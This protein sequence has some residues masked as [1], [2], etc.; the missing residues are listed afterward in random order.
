MATVN[1]YYRSKKK[2]TELTVKLRYS[3]KSENYV[4][5]AKTP[6]STYLYVWEKYFN[7]K[8]NDA[9]IRDKVFELRT[10]LGK[11]ESYILNS[12]NDINSAVSKKWLE[13]KTSNYFNS[14]GDIPTKI[15]DYVEYYK[16]VRKNEIK[17]HFVRKL[18]VLKKKLAAFDVMQGFSHSLTSINEIFKNQFVDYLK[19]KHYSDN[20]IKKQVS[21]VKQICSYARYNGM[22][23]SHQLEKLSVKSENVP[24]IYLSFN[25]LEKIEK[26]EESTL[27]TQA[28]KATRDWL[29]ISAYTGQRISDFMRFTKDMIREEK[30]KVFIEFTQTKTKK[31]MTIPLHDK[32]LKIL[33]NYNGDFPQRL[34][35]Q[36][37]NDY[38]KSVCKKANITQTIKG[39]KSTNLGT[40]ENPIYRYKTD[41]YPKYKLITS[42]I[43]RRSFATNFYG[44]IPT[45]YLMYVTGHSTESMFLNYI[46][47]S[48]KDLALEVANYF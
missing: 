16:E 26:L 40:K 1:F 25:E 32:V 46:G 7:K 9:Q 11:L 22:E 24:K 44:E 10:E 20:Y 39:R 45:T 35:D 6:I 12:F 38:L 41:D 34:L 15:S 19:S 8:I 29:I 30:G 47:K 4:H 17:P 3:F 18:N 21:L 36:K 13:D 48:N 28:L 27:N 42:H 14:S 5:T 23:V 33:R 2:Q 31:H 37:Y 43:G